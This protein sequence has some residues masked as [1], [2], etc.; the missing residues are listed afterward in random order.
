MHVYI[1]INVYL[2]FMLAKQYILTFLLYDYIG[3]ANKTI[4]EVPIATWSIPA[5]SQLPIS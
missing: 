4:P 1:C 3:T 5:N 2:Q